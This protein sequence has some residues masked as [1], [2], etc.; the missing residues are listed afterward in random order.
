MIQRCSVEDQ[1]STTYNKAT[2]VANAL[3]VVEMVVDKTIIIILLQFRV[4]ML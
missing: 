4:V 2:K 1:D 3:R